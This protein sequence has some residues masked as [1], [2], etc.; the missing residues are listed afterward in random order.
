MCF[1]PAEDPKVAVA[2]YTEREGTGM[3]VA[4]PIARKF[5]L[6]VLTEPANP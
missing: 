1:A 6:D 4:A 2:V 5:L 3:D